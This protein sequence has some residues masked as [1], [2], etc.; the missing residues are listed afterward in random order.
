MLEVLERDDVVLLDC[1]MDETWNA[2]GAHIPGAARLP[3]PS[4]AD[5]A[6][7]TLLAPEVLA[8]R[9]AAAGATRDADVVVYCGGGVSA[10]FAFAALEA[11]GY[12]HLRVYDGSWSEWS[13]DPRLPTEPHAT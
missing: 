3:A 9:A 2:A 11:A 5:A 7:G 4:L 1:R 10:S 12:E 6:A 13:L 8:R